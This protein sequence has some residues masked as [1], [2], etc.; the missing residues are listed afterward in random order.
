MSMNVQWTTRYKISLDSLISIKLEGVCVCVCVCVCKPLPSI[1][2]KLDVV[3]FNRSTVALK[4]VSFFYTC[5]STKAEAHC[6]LIYLPIAERRIEIDLY[7]PKESENKRKETEVKYNQIFLW[8]FDHFYN[9]KSA[10]YKS[11]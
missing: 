8:L 9:S 1:G 10:I 11:F 5:C 4:W 6:L 2:R 7:L 3:N